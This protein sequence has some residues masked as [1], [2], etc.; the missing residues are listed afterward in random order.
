MAANRF[1]SHS[2]LDA[3]NVRIVNALGKIVKFVVGVTDLPRE[4]TDRVCRFDAM[5]CFLLQPCFA[6][7]AQILGLPEDPPIGSLVQVHGSAVYGS[8]PDWLTAFAQA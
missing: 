8:V 4:E 5:S 3:L 6:H 2:P 7:D 1:A